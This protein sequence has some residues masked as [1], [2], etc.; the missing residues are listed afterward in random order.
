VNKDRRR[1]DLVLEQLRQRG[2]TGVIPRRVTIWIYGN[3]RDLTSIAERLAVDG[4]PWIDIQDQGDKF[5]LIAEREQQASPDAIHAMTGAINE[6]ISDT[7][8]IFDG[9]ETSVERSN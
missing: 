6:I 5:S 8:A 4:W 1:D 2:D 3:E 7:C 9:W